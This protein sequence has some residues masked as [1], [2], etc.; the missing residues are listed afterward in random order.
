MLFVFPH[1]VLNLEYA[2]PVKEVALFFQ[3]FV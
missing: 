1:Y 3:E 2:V